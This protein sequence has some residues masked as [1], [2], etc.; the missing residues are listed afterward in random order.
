M[1]APLAAA[2]AIIGAVGSAAGTVGSFAT[3]SSAA[4]AQNRSRIGQY[5]HQLKMRRLAWQDTRQQYATKLGQYGNE[6]AANR[7]AANIAYAGQQQKLND[8]YKKAAF[9]QQA[10]LVQLT[11]GQGQMAAAG[12]LGKSAERLD[13]DMVRQFGRNQAIQAESLL[14]AQYGLQNANRNIRRELMSANNQAFSDVAV[15]PKPDM[16][17]PPPAMA[18]GPSPLS[19]IGGLLSAGSDL[20]TGLLNIPKPAQAPLNNPIKPLTGI[21]G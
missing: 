6:L 13:L 1:C 5:R 9:S 10:Q 4:A 20:G 15:A 11:K 18:Q 8:I 12:R 14:S 16:A 7:E 17:P 21:I 2:P 19:L 3:S